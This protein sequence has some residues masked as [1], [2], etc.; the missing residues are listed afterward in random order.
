MR[1]IQR[2]KKFTLLIENLT[3]KDYKTGAQAFPTIK[4]LQCYAAL[5]GFQEGRKESLDKEEKDNIEWHT[6][7][8]GDYT[9]Y[10]YMIAL[11][12]TKSLSVLK[13]DVENSDAGDFEKDMVKIF[14]E[15]AHGGFHIIQNWLD[16]YSGDPYG[17]KAIISGLERS[18]YIS[19]FTEN[20]EFDEVD[21]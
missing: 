9:D 8:N 16:K 10:I 15:Y 5:L 17:S 20:E 1:S 13:Y 11:A 3:G 12:D 7:N 6:F 4:A 14:E 18:N 19:N 21:L 2:S